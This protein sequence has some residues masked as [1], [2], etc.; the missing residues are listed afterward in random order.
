MFTVNVA[1]CTCEGNVA[2]ALEQEEKLCNV[3]KTVR[4]FTYLGDRVCE[5]GG[6]EAVVTSR[7][8]LASC[9]TC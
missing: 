9:L 4:Q 7:I 8:S 6:C 3:V 5:G 2:E 1:S